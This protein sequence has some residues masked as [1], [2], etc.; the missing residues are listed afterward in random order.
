VGVWENVK[1]Y[2]N[3]RITLISQQSG[4]L[5][6][7][8][9][10]TADNLPPTTYTPNLLEYDISYVTPNNRID[11]AYDHVGQWFRVKYNTST[12]SLTS[13][14]IQLTTRY[15]RQ[16]TVIALVD[17]QHQPVTAS[18]GG[19]FVALTD[20][21]GQ[22]LNSTS[23]AA[24]AVNATG[25]ELA[26]TVFPTDSSTNPLNTFN[27]SGGRGA[28]YPDL[29]LTEL[30][31]LTAVADAS[32]YPLSTLYTVH[33]SISSSNA[34]LVH[35]AAGTY[36]TPN[37][38]ASVTITVLATSYEP[39]LQING[40]ITFNFSGT[41]A[42]VAALFAGACNNNTNGLVTATNIG[43]TCTIT[44]T[45]RGLAGQYS[46][47]T[48]GC[49]QSV[50]TTPVSTPFGTGP[51]LA[52]QGYLSLITAT[53]GRDVAGTPLVTAPGGVTGV[54]LYLS[55]DIASVDTVSGAMAASGDS[56]AVTFADD[57]GN[58]Y[59]T[60]ANP[61]PVTLEGSS[62]YTLSFDLSQSIQTTPVQLPGVANSYGILLHSLFMYNAG[63]T[64]S[65]VF[66]YDQPNPNFDPATIQ[67][68]YGFAVP[69]A[70]TRDL[71]F[72]EG[73]PF[74]TGLSFAACNT[75]WNGFDPNENP[76][77]GN[78]F[79]SGVYQLFYS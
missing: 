75:A 58:I 46:I 73:S 56:L 24:N 10:L 66:L 51:A 9:A 23:T 63:P 43:N 25:V 48:S 30:T 57:S 78:M 67:P 14:P 5:S 71:I 8:W 16:P 29:S 47:I 52:Q 72:P 54:A 7:Q 65:W 61:L 53:Y 26:L 4:Q 62:L 20:F 6:L 19:L 42:T 74:Y 21:C 37:S 33:N 22:L 40:G 15:E 18:G 45:T 17:H 39:G 59:G 38:Y 69:A 28:W 44:A 41:P 77:L 79:V 12:G 2:D 13:Q 11:Y 34:L 3:V 31:L 64:T 70:T 35:P 60:A 49:L 68:I 36:A 27:V 32:G 76:G 55:S 50:P 1:D